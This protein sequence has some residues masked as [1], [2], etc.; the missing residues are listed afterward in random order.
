MAR[1]IRVIPK[2]RG[3]P[4]TGRDPVSAI[5]LPPDLTATIDKWAAQNNASSRS[6]AIR[7]LV[8][9]G[10]AGARPM[11]RRSPK[12]AAKAA[13]LPT[14][15]RPGG[16]WPANERK[17]YSERPICRWSQSDRGAAELPIPGLAQSQD[18]HAFLVLP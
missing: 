5:R 10:L 16:G 2:K 11:K 8:A 14:P 4:A 9:L 7:R 12:A 3:R 17:R 15:T 6:Q 18:V 13:R 1:S